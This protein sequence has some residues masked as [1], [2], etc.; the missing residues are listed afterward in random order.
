MGKAEHC[1]TQAQLEKYAAFQESIGAVEKAGHRRLNHQLYDQQNELCEEQRLLQKLDEREAEAHRVA[2]E[3]LLAEQLAKLR[4]D[5]LRDEKERQRVRQES[6]ELQQLE[7]Q[8]YQAYVNKE[9]HL[10]LQWADAA[11]SCRDSAKPAMEKERER[12]A[13]D[14]YRKKHDFE[15]QEKEQKRLV[16]STRYLEGLRQQFVEKDLQ[17][18]SE[19][20]QF[21][22]D[23]AVIDEIV[24]QIEEEDKRRQE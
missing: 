4:D 7:R 19:F 20:Q 12:E 13:L 15:T 18:E 8:L 6:E 11:G 17:K 2:Q 14:E 3:T 10:Q 5:K 1:L 24:K 23:K 22:K 9:R 16:E 21:L